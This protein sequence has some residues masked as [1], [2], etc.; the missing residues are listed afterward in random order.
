MQNKNNNDNIRDL[1]LKVRENDDEAFKKL[2]QKYTPLIEASVNYFSSDVAFGVY[3]DD[4]RQ[5]ASVAFYKSILAFDIDQDDVAFGLYAKICIQHA[6]VSQLRTLK[7]LPNTFPLQ[8]SEKES[9]GTESFDPAGRILEQER[10]K[11]IYDTIR[12]NLSDYEYSVWQMYI[13]GRSSLDIANAL[14]T[15]KRSVDNAIYRIRKKLRDLLK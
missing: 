14:S 1:I 8:S 9:N 2:F 15:D 12:K 6:L 11:V 7:K 13:A 5:E 4:L 3:S 10:V